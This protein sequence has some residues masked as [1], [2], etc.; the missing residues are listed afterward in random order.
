MYMCSSIFSSLK[1]ERS[2]FRFIL[3]GKLIFF[4]KKEKVLK[5]KS[6]KD[7]HFYR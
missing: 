5:K 7:T 6:T 1:F 2:K 3:I 4:K